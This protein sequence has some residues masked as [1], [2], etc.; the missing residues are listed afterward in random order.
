MKTSRARIALAIGLSLLAHLLMLLVPHASLPPIEAPLPPLAA[1]LEKLP[2]ID[3]RPIQP[4]A[5]P[6]RKKQSPADRQPSENTAPSAE[7]AN[8][9]PAEPQHDPEPSPPEVSQTVKEAEPV[10]PLP[11]RAQLTFVAYKGESFEIGEA[12]QR[13]E[14]GDDNSYTLK[15][16][17]NTTGL[18]SIFKT[19]IATQQSSGFITRHGL[20]PHEFN[21]TRNT[22][23]NKEPVGLKFAWEEGLLIFLNGNRMPLPEQTQ[24]IISFP[25]QL[26]QLPLEK[27]TIQ[28]HI[29]NGRKL[30][31]YEFAVGEEEEIETRLGKLRTLPLRKI[32]KPGEEGL[33]IWLGL[34]YRLLPVKIQQIER[35]GEIAGQMVVSDIRVSDE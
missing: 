30:G 1:R 34:E 18:A 22:S 26:S 13:F 5:A 25:Y 10:H 28:M 23:R 2:A 3:V 29:S 12:R 33:V 11:K 8:A 24:D 4:K 19:Y 27:G 31:R 9:M 32:H 15:V 17:M 20:Q 16:D 7:P 21:E 6:S 14:R 35:N